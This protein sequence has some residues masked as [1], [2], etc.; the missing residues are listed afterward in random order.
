MRACS[1]SSDSGLSSPP[2][3]LPTGC[4]REVVP[5]H[6]R[7]NSTTPLDLFRPHG[8]EYPPVFVLCHPSTRKLAEKIVEQANLQE[9]TRSVSSPSGAKVDLCVNVV[10]YCVIYSYMHKRA[11][12]HHKGKCIHRMRCSSSSFIF[13]FGW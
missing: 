5:P 3:A 8:D 13:Q 2:T 4:R 12:L 11:L 9:T 6:K 10:L 1:M 7:R